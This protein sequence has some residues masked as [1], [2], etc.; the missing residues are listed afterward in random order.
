MLPS[1]IGARQSP[2]FGARGTPESVRMFGVVLRSLTRTAMVTE[3]LG[4]L[5]AFTLT[6]LIHEQEELGITPEFYKDDPQDDEPAILSISAFRR[7]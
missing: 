2:V 5:L 3:V 4:K 1:P 7:T 6:C